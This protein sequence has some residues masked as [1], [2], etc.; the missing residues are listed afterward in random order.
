MSPKG[1][2][3]AFSSGEI[4]PEVACRVDIQKYYIYHGANEPKQSHFTEY[5][6]LNKDQKDHFNGQIYRKFSIH[7]NYFLPL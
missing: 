7:P 2:Q 4:S 5:K 1:I 3:P 6:S